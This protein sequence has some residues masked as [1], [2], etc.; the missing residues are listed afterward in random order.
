MRFTPNVSDF[1]IASTHTQ[2][3]LQKDII[4]CETFP[5]GRVHI[6]IASLAFSNYGKNTDYGFIFLRACIC[7]LFLGLSAVVDE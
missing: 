6:N 5:F 7:F 4:S 1:S 2:K 3:I